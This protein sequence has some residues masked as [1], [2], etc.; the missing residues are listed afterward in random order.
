MSTAAPN[1]CGSTQDYFRALGPHV[2]R[3]KWRRAVAFGGQRVFS[4]LCAAQMKL[5]DEPEKK[6]RFNIGEAL[7]RNELALLCDASGDSSQSFGFV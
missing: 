6:S 7:P 2:Y 1:Q 3:A 4:A 5:I